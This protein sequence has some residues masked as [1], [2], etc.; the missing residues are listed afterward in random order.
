MLVFRLHEFAKEKK[1][2][3]KR[4]DDVMKMTTNRMRNECFISELK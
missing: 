2:K 4:T 3:L 1:S